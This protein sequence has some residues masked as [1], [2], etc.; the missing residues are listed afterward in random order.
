M[1]NRYDCSEYC[2][3]ANR[4]IGHHADQVHKKS[5]R[6]G[7][8]GAC[9]LHLAK[10]REFSTKTDPMPHACLTLMFF[11]GFGKLEVFWEAT[12]CFAR[13]GSQPSKGFKAVGWLVGWLVGR[14]PAN[15]QIT[16]PLQQQQ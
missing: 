10:N 3:E 7:R 4:K 11:G 14:K 8:H 16:S 5:Y 12:F 13:S 9:V 15:I 1:T 6:R 2:P